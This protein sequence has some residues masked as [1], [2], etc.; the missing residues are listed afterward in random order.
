[1]AQCETLARPNMQTVAIHANAA[2]E[3]FFI[4]QFRCWIAGYSLAET[5]CWNLAWTALVNVVSP[6]AAKRIYEAFQSFT[7]TLTAQARRSIG[8]RPNVCRCL[9]RD[10]FLALQLVAASQ[11]NDAVDETIAAANLLGADD[12]RLLLSASRS[13]AQALKMKGFVLAPVEALRPTIA[14]DAQSSKQRILH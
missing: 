11:R 8:W 10:E 13:L 1:M 5:Y 2:A 4:C 3:R 6:R 12:V 9:C 7:Y 14:F